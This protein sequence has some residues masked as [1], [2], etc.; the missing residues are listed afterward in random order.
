MHVTDG[1]LGREIVDFAESHGSALIVLASSGMTPDERLLLEPH[2]ESAHDDQRWVLGSI[3][4]R[5]AT[6]ATVPVW[7]R[8]KFVNGWGPRGVVQQALEFTAS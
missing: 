8:K 5:V 1:H 4:E 3:T 2:T 6:H 7:V